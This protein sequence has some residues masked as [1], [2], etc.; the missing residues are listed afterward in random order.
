MANTYTHQF[1]GLDVT[2]VGNM[3]NV[4]SVVWYRTIATDANGISAYSTN[5]VGLEEPA[6][7]ASFIE[8]SNLTEQQVMQ[9]AIDRAGSA[10]IT[11]D[12]QM[13]DKKLEQKKQQS[14][15]LS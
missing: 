12:K 8:F 1:K 13:A 3:Q 2:N 6:D 5:A 9:W 7:E 14:L 10:Q 4:V 11:F 15:Q